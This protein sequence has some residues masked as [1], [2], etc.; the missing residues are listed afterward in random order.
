MWNEIEIMGERW[1][2][3]QRQ[4]GETKAK[5]RTERNN[6]VIKVIRETQQKDLETVYS[7]LSWERSPISLKGPLQFPLPTQHQNH[8]FPLSNLCL[9][10]FLLLPPS[11]LSLHPRFLCTVFLPSFLLSFSLAPSFLLPFLIHP[12]FL[13]TQLHK[14]TLN[15]YFKYN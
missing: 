6:E 15:I 14:E 3:S 1:R 11:I 7:A 9:E 12:T 8:L 2:K 10:L 4:R 5:Q 13:L